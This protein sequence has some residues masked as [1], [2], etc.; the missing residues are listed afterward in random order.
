MNNAFNTS[1]KNIRQEG[2]DMLNSLAAVRGVNYSR[3]VHCFILADRIDELSSLWEQAVAYGAT[4]E[5]S[6]LA[7]SQQACIATLMD[8]LISLTGYKRE[9]LIEIA[10]D[11][12][13]LVVT[14]DT[15]T[16]KAYELSRQGQAMGDQ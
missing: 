11:A 10:D 14:T 6:L 13:R 3:M 12:K 1:V 16:E 4:K 15:L 2:A 5:A 7:Q 9:E 8:N